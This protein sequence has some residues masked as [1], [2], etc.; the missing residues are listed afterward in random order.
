MT[1]QGSQVFFDSEPFLQIFLPARLGLGRD[2][3]GAGTRPFADESHWN[4]SVG[5]S[6]ARPEG[7][8]PAHAG[9]ARLLFV[10][11]KTEKGIRGCKQFAVRGQNAEFR[12]GLAPDLGGEH[13]AFEQPHLGISAPHG[14]TGFVPILGDRQPDY[15]QTRVPVELNEKIRKQG[16][17]GTRGAWCFKNL[18]FPEVRAWRDRP[19]LPAGIGYQGRPFDREN[20][21]L[22]TARRAFPAAGQN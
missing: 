6:L 14:G 15:F 10:T 11:L 8:R 18:A 13:P 19:R 7:N 21:C 16:D 4:L 20:G 9:H 2:H 17:G 22:H 5:L 1:A 3:A 12:H